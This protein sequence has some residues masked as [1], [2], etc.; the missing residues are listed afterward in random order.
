MVVV[1][2]LFSRP[3]AVA[4][5]VV[6]LLLA[7][8]VVAAGSYAAVRAVRHPDYADHPMGTGGAVL[9]VHFGAPGTMTMDAEPVDGSARV[10]R[11]SGEF[12]SEQSAGNHHG[13][14]FELQEGTYRVAV[15][16]D[17]VTGA[18]EVSVAGI[19]GIDAWV[20]SGEM[21]FQ[22]HQRHPGDHDAFHDG[23]GSGM[24]AGSLH[25]GAEG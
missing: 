5:A 22:P 6:L 11:T 8:G 12:V 21:K 23:G 17:D 20:E 25:Q 24:H 3:V 9:M 13:V 4:A 1:H 15:R 7:T 2:R 18:F 14:R 10:E 16:I 19:V